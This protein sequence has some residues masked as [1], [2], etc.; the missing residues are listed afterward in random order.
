V[1]FRPVLV[2][3]ATGYIGGRLVPRLLEAGHRVR[4]LAREPRKLDGRPWAG[5]PRVEIVAGDTADIASLRRAME[6]CG[7]AFYLVHSMV[8]AGREYA[9]RDRAMA[10]AFARAAEDTGVERIV[11]LGGLGDLGRACPSTS[12]PGARSRR[13]SRR[14]RRR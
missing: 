9:E 5:D 11:Y 4:C 2:T 10:K 7:P 12:P 13:F 1:R 8:A 6:G 3:G 14:A